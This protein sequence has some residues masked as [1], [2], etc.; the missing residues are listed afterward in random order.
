MDIRNIGDVI[1]VMRVGANI[2]ATAGGS[3]DATEVT[4]TIFDRLS[5]GS[6]TS[7]VLAV[8]YTA[9]LAEDETLSLTYSVESGAESDLS[10]ATVL[11]TGTVVLATG[12]TGGSTEAGI[13]EIDLN[14]LAA[15]RYVRADLTPDLS[16]SGTD[17]AALAAV[18]VCGGMDRLPQ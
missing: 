4:G 1:K 17:T 9:T 2:A 3:G 10:D 14:L 5:I 7:G 8:S 15:G 16:A 6:P 12:D 18:V 11:K 13:A